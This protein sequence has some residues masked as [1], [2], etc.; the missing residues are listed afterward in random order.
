MP[1]VQPLGLDATVKRQGPVEGL[2]S[3]GVPLM[4]TVESGPFFFIASWH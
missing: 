3:L 2:R 1:M 4:E